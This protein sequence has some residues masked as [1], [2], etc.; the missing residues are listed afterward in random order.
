MCVCVCN[1]R[2]S[3]EGTVFA[4]MCVRVCVRDECCGRRST[5]LTRGLAYVLDRSTLWLERQAGDVYTRQAIVD[6][7]RSR[8]AYKLMEMDDACRFLRAGR[9]VVD[10][11]AAPGGWCQVAGR[12]VTA[13]GRVLGLDLRAIDPFADASHVHLLQAD[14]TEPAIVDTIRRW[15]VDRP[16]HVVLR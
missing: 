11:G 5:G 9:N 10:L 13:S 7:F 1:S 2:E 16:I 14:A 12:R 3:D 8:S 4:S 15:F 6:G